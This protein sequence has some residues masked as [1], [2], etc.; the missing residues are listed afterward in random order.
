MNN[1]IG[2]I[3][4]SEREYLFG[5]FRF[6]P[7]QQSLLRGETSLR[8]SSRALEVLATLLERPG[9]LVSKSE[10]IARVWPKSIVED[11]NLKVHV[12]ALRRALDEGEGHHYVGTVSG[13]G[14]RFVAP[15]SCHPLTAHPPPPARK[16]YDLP[17]PANRM[18]G[19]DDTA[20]AMMRLLI[21]QR[22]ATIVGPGGIGKTT[23]ALAL[24]EALYRQHGIETCFVD[25]SPLRE[26]Q[27][28]AGALAA[29]LGLSIHS[30]DATPALV[31]CLRDR[32]LLLILDSCEHVIDAAAALAERLIAGAAGVMVLSTS[33]EPLRAAGEYVQRLAP[34]DFPGDALPRTAAH[35][36]QYAA[37]ELFAERAAQCVDG[38][39][40]NDMDAPA[41]AE[42]CRRLEGNALAIE[43]AARR[44]DA[45]SARELAHRLDDRFRLL[46]RGLR[47]ALARHRTL[48]AALDWSYEYLS[49]AEQ[50]ILRA[51]SVFAGP[52]TLDAAHAL[53]GKAGADELAVIDG[54]ADLVAKSL[55][56][57]IVT[58]SLTYYRLLDTTKAYA[59]DKLEGSGEMAA[60]RRR[61]ADWF[62]LLLERA[63]IEWEA[64]PTA[65]WLADYG[66]AIDDVRAALIWA[67][68]A[69]GDSSIAIALTAAAI[70]LWMHL[71]LLDECCQRVG[72][73]LAAGAAGSQPSARDEMKFHAALAAA[74]LYAH[75]PLAATAD[76]WTSALSLAEALEDNEYR[77]RALWGLAVYRSYTGEY[78]EVL[79]L[80][81]RFRAIADSRGDR[82]AYISVD[83]L[84]ATALHY[85]GDQQSAHRHLKVML[86]RYVAPVQRSHIA[87]FQLDQRAAALGTLANVRWIQGFPDQALL[88]AEDA[89]SG[90][91]D[92]D[93]ALSL[94]NALAHAAC[95]IALYLGDYKQAERLLEELFEHLARHAL[96]VWSALWRCLRGMLL[97][98]GGEVRGLPMLA[99][100]LDELRQAGFRLRYRS[101][102]G[103]LAAA[104]G[105]HGKHAEAMAAIGEALA[106]CKASGEQWC[107]AELL[108]IKG[109]LLEA[110]DEQAAE[111]LY[112]R[113]LHVAASQRALSWQLRTAINLATLRI[114]QGR[115]DEGHAVL[116]AVYDQ[117]TEGFESLDLRRAR[118][119]LTP[120]RAYRLCG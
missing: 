39:R 5:P 61:H 74:L 94:F 33:R 98:Q 82:A 93:H 10:L 19:R 25:L 1:W 40:L 60:I 29:A 114:R 108:R 119:L 92:S 18:I 112:L 30:S 42:I 31:A 14:Y 12:A 117:F 36:L 37:V 13:R 69:D 11:C 41:V 58:G 3:P 38:Y 102:L 110:T 67:R 77:L 99:A 48:S 84:I 71:S 44:M 72:Q 80:A 52:F 103:V 76:A 15:V 104:W 4:L 17:V 91:R 49:P 26:Q 59:Q 47:G 2:G 68:S 35:A 23:V 20:L 116:S 90:A 88:A 65:D 45:F 9:E 97:V 115:A 73:A 111:T 43:L 24:A 89:L 79:A 87:R 32:R 64:R 70:P 81:R 96:T 63:S 55:I 22:F 95:P 107:L 78:R 34:L 53:C 56:S 57:P 7:A 8:L 21:A 62:R 75:G 50:A 54:V 109:E 6:I 106:G 120:D 101:Y 85:L 66:R 113:S 46:K 28:V 105:R 83:R 16:A 51:V 118:Q 27:F 86:S 100:A